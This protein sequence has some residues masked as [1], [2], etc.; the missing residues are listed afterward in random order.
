MNLTTVPHR[1]LEKKAVAEYLSLTAITVKIEGRKY[2]HRDMIMKLNGVTTDLNDESEEERTKR[3]N[4]KMQSDTE[5]AIGEL[6]DRT[7]EEI[8]EGESEGEVDDY[9][10]DKED[11]AGIINM[12][13]A[14]ADI[15]NE[16]EGDTE[17]ID[18]GIDMNEN[19]TG[20]LSCNETLNL[21]LHKGNNVKVK[22]ASL[23][24]LCFEDFVK[25]G[26]HKLIEKNLEVVRHRNQCRCVSSIE[27]R[28]KIYERVN[29]GYDVVV[30]NVK[31]EAFTRLNSF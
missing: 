19:A 23:K 13:I 21:S 20:D 29:D 1:T 18:K 16:G 9:E 24:K 3:W 27:L 10:E 2:R 30:N 22:L 28:S 25:K 11:N 31:S 14:L 5:L 26:K 4:I 8:N 17:G 7:F 15:G 12:T 6:A